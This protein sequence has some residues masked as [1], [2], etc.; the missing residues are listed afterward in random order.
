MFTRLVLCFVLT[1][2][3]IGALPAAAATPAPAPCS[4][5]PAATTNPGTLTGTIKCLDF[6]RGNALITIVSGQ[7]EMTTILVTP[8][9][10][11]QANG[12]LPASTLRG[13]SNSVIGSGYRSITDLRAGMPVQAYTTLSSGKLTA[14]IL[15]MPR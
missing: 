4:S 3:A 13:R 5:A 12:T 6:E 14:T 8:G 2:A 7:N 15:I 9:T 10:L 11:L 1:G